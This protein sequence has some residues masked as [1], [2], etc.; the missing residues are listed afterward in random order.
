VKCRIA[1]I[2]S[3]SSSTFVPDGPFSRVRPPVCMKNASKK[4]TKP[5]AQAQNSAASN[6][7]S[8]KLVKLQD[9]VSKL[10][11]V[12]R[13]RKGRPHT[14]GSFVDTGLAAM[15]KI[16]GMGDYVIEEN[17]LSDVLGKAGSAT[18]NVP[19]FSPMANNRVRHRECLG[20]VRVPADTNFN[21]VKK[22][23]FNPTDPDTF[24]W[25]NNMAGGYTSY[26]VHG[27]ALIYETNTSEYSATPYMG[28]VCLGTRYDTRESD[29]TSMVEMQNAKFSVS[30]KPSL[31]ILHPLECKRGFQQVDTWLCRRGNESTT[32]Y[33]YDKCNIYVAT[34]GITAAAGTVLGRLWLTYDIELINPVLPLENIQIM[35]GS[36]YWK[37]GWGNTT[38]KNFN[39]CMITLGSRA[40]QEEGP[41]LY[42]T[43]LAAKTSSTAIYSN[44]GIMRIVKPGT[45]VFGYNVNGATLGPSF[46]P[47]TFTLNGNAKTWVNQDS[48]SI[49]TETFHTHQWTL[50]VTD[51]ADDGINHINITSVAFP[52]TVSN[53]WGC[54]VIQT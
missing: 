50:Q 49:S 3:A 51:V 53:C 18:Q 22:L 27:A 2:D 11:T 23:K 33:L 16:F 44:A 21:I 41:P 28:T 32:T 45:Y 24:P 52:G 46:V 26:K 29:F 39:D 42:C 9:A 54:I 38:I 48:G 1:R 47:W 12:S 7:I 15:G 5:P 8:N 40:S 19:A 36:D 17:S 34:E 14:I 30:A 13:S 37:F 6:A 10:T 20:V 25:L 35:A 31:N 4:K 43:T